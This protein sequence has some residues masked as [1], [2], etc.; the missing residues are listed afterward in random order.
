MP[1][2]DPPDGYDVGTLDDATVTDDTYRYW[3]TDDENDVAYWFDLREEVPLRKK[4]QILE[5]NMRT[6]EGP[7]GNPQQTI[8]VGYYDEMIEYCV[9]DWFGEQEQ[10]EDV[11][12]LTVFLNRMSTDFEDLQNEVPQP[13]EASRRGEEGK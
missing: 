11:P 13:F 3:V 6:E 7:D 5:R 4:N 9:V 2:I 10:H 12:S 1:D 8:E